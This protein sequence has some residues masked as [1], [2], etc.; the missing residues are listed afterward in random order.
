MAD[1]IR[2][3]QLE[4]IDRLTI[5]DIMVVNNENVNTNAIKF[6]NLVNSIQEY[7]SLTFQGSVAFTGA[8][9]L[10]STTVLEKS[11]TDLTDVTLVNTQAT[12]ILAYNGVTWTNTNLTGMDFDLDLTELNDVTLT[13]PQNGDHLVYNGNTWVNQA[14]G[15]S[16]IGYADLSVVQGVAVAGGGLSY[17]N[18]SGVFTFQ[19]DSNAGYATTG[20]VS[21]AVAVVDNRLSAISGI[22]TGNSTLGTFNG[23]TITNDS[24]VKGALQ[25]LETALEAIVPGIQ[26]TA[27]S[28]EIATASGQGNLTYNNLDGKF[29]FTPADVYTAAAAD[30]AFAP[31]GVLADAALTGTPTAPT[32]NAS[33]NSTQVAT[34]AF[35][36]QEITG[37]NTA[38]LSTT[39][40][41][42]LV[43]NAADYAAF[44]SAIAAL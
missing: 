15:A 24:N 26:Y 34:T 36:Q 12:Q 28:V 3:S 16:S 30:A 19:P 29:T 10:P 43:A 37:N 2:I 38:Y 31:I 14:M 33:T 13:T 23:T 32:A 8:V 40:L 25:E 44:Q 9:T 7:P 41:K 39:S 22:S 11:L 20:D 4:L 27:L 5:D 6:S 18:T 21:S 42:S 17:N 1:S 35:V